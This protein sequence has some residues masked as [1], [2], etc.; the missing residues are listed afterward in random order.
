MP[1]QRDII[2]KNFKFKVDSENGFLLIKQGDSAAWN[3]TR[4]YRIRLRNIINCYIEGPF[5]G[6][7]ESDQP[8]YDQWRFVITVTRCV[9]GDLL[10]R[11]VV[12][13]VQ[14]QEHAEDILEGITNRLGF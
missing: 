6:Y 11:D 5:G 8:H 9:D 7:D 3:I 10:E 12:M 2:F 4:S 1:N 14:G 13:Y